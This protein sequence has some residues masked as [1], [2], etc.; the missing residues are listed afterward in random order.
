MLIQPPFD[1]IE[2]HASVLADYGHASLLGHAIRQHVFAVEAAGEEIIA[3]RLGSIAQINLMLL[4]WSC[5]LSRTG[6]SAARVSGWRKERAPAMSRTGASPSSRFR[7]AA[8]SM[9]LEDATRLPAQPDLAVHV[10]APQVV[11][12]TAIST[13]CGYR[14]S[15]APLRGLIVWAMRDS[16]HG[17][18]GKGSRKVKAVDGHAERAH[19]CQNRAKQKGGRPCGSLCCQ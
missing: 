10:P 5:H 12:G 2:R 3:Q 17:R 1:C 15:A 14:S 7:R 13:L 8:A 4:T 9:Q 16:K 6:R 11:T 18:G 19:A